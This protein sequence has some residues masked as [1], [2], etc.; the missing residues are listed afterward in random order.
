MVGK[1][2][3]TTTTTGALVA[4]LQEKEEKVRVVFITESLCKPHVIGSRVN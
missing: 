3:L 2:I 1:P 4:D